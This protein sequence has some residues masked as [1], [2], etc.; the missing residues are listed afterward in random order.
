MLIMENILRQ[1]SF[2]QYIGSLYA[3]VYHF[4]YWQNLLNKQVK[5]FKKIYMYDKDFY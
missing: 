4:G 5:F 3:I 1:F 2:N